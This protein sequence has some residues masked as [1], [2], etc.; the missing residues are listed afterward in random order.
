MLQ[1][2]ILYK[3]NVKHKN[4]EKFCSLLQNKIKYYV[5]KL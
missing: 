5:T 2:K 3:I 4:A 1:C